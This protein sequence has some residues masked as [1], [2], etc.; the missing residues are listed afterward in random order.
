MKHAQQ[1]SRVEP[2]SPT[3]SYARRRRT[4]IALNL[5]TSSHT[6]P[7]CKTARSRTNGARSC[8]RF[9][10][11]P[12]ATPGRSRAARGRTQDHSRKRVSPVTAMVEQ[13]TRAVGELQLEVSSLPR[14]MFRQKDTQSSRQ[15]PCHSSRPCRILP[16]RRRT[17]TKS[18]STRFLRCLHL[19]HSGQRSRAICAGKT[20]MQARTQTRDPALRS[21]TSPHSSN[22]PSQHGR[23]TYT[24]P[25]KPSVC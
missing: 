8:P 7:G 11:S 12:S 5:K 20:A 13:I 14:T 9:R 1:P 15:Y 17:T 16:G 25:Q 18:I 6:R 23:G 10:P 22:S 19:S 24:D 4:V 3:L 21:R 2:G